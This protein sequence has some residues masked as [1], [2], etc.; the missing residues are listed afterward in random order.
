METDREIDVPEGLVRE[1]NRGNC[2]A[3][4]G[5]GFS[6]AAELP[7]WI[8]LLRRMASSPDVDPEHCTAVSELTEATGGKKPSAHALDQAAQMLADHLGTE[9]FIELLR[10]P[11]ETTGTL[12]GRM[13]RRLQR[14]HAVP[15]R[16][17]LTSNSA[18][19]SRASGSCGWIFTPRTTTLASSSSGTRPA[20]GAVFST[21]SS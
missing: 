16:A 5:A 19:S 11:L 1:I 15:F 7:G 8:M 21:R 13:A 17:I 4:V 9:R 6:A 2:I 20:K 14:L 12:P 10:E 3:F 18:L